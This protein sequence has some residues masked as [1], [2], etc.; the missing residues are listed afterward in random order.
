MNVDL[1]AKDRLYNE[2]DDLM[3][4]NGFTADIPCWRSVSS[5]TISSLF[6]ENYR[7]S[8]LFYVSLGVFLIGPSAQRM[9][10]PKLEQM[11]AWARL[12]Q[13]TKVTSGPQIALNG[14]GS[15]DTD[16][17]VNE[18]VVAVKDVG[19]DI[20]RELST[21]NGTKQILDKYGEMRW[22]IGSVIKDR[23]YGN[24]SVKI[25]GS[26]PLRDWEIS[27]S[28]NPFDPQRKSGQA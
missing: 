24:P 28:V 10:K 8:F 11:H 16:I 3:V 14:D 9:K 18:V 23:M 25:V 12:S 1:R 27:G 2:I 19:L 5:E 7:K 6:I 17:I 22:Q 4:R 15:V 21:C 20:L 13:L 26:L